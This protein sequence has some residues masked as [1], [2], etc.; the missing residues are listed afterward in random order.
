MLEPARV[1]RHRRGDRHAV[2]DRL[3]D[4]RPGLLRHPHRSAPTAPT[5]PSTCR[6]GTC[7]RT[8]SASACWRCW[9][10]TRCSPSLLRLE[11]TEGALL[12]NPDQVQLSPDPV[13]R[14]RRADAARRFR[15]RLLVAVLPAPLPAARPEDRP[16]LRRR[17]AA[18]RERRQHRDRAR[19]P[20]AGRFAR[21]GSGRRGHRDRG[22]APAAAPARPHARPGLPVRAARL[23][24]R[25][26]RAAAP[27]W[28]R[29]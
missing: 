5:S 16:L 4:L 27:W 29:D 19:D 3:A 15:H 8:A 18:R 6:R 2:A 1:P 21:A 10:A 17:A 23:D 28:R 11:V 12:E 22:A 25:D 14:G 24:D 26:R 20:A 9:P 13:A 7:A